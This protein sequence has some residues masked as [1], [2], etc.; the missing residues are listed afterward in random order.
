[1][2]MDRSDAGRQLALELHRFASASPVVLALPRGGLA[3]GR[4]VA[5]ALGAKM[6]VL[7][8]RKLGAPHNPEFAIGAV[9]ES[10]IVVID[11]DSASAARVSDVLRDRLISEATTEI[12]R[13]VDVYR[14]GRPLTDVAGRTVILVDD[15]LATGA[16]AEAAVRVVRALAAN[17]VILAV[18]TGSRQALDRLTPLCDEVVCLETPEWF[19]S[20]GSQYDSFP[21]VTDDEVVALLHA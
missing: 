14:G 10:G 15:G 5:D 4:E 8:V 11:T 13:R 16:T 18:P 6:D 19:A 3:V 12:E 2:F 1:M 20:V 17:P 7:N 21:Q 9:G